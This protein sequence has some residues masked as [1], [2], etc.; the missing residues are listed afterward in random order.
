MSE[1]SES[2][3]PNWEKI[4]D[5][6]DKIDNVIDE[7]IKDKLSFLEIDMALYMIE[8]KMRQEKHRIMTRLYLEEVQQEES[9]GKP[10][11]NTHFYG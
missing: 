10:T 9:D 1:E 7:S 5:L 3:K 8:E 6:C 2:F 11:K 4:Q